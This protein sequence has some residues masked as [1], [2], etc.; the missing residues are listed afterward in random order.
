LARDD[1]RSFLHDRRQANRRV[2][3]YGASP[4]G[5]MLLNVCGLT[6]DDVAFVA[7]TS[8]GKRSRSLPGSHIPVV[9]MEVLAQDAP[10]DV[11]ILPWTDPAQIAAQFQP[12]RQV[13]TQL[14]TLLPRVSRV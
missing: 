4:R 14:W 10:D 6:T 11:L 1:I 2:A 3:A 8:C 9:P 5:T 12:L 7:D 13:G